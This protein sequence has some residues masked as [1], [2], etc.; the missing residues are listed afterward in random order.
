MPI[1]ENAPEQPLRV[2][3]L[4]FSL[5][6]YT[7]DLNHYATYNFVYRNSLSFCSAAVDSEPK[8]S[9][10]IKIATNFIEIAYCAKFSVGTFFS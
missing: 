8:G 6:Q 5:V 3:C 7:I 4:V 1:S 10:Y 9:Y 2:F